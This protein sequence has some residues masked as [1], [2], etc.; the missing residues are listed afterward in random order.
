MFCLC[1]LLNIEEE[2]V[3][4]QV[5]V[6]PVQAFLPSVSKRNIQKNSI[7]FVFLQ[8]R[9]KLSECFQSYLLGLLIYTSLKKMCHWPRDWKQMKLHQRQL[10]P[11]VEV[12]VTV[13]IHKTQRR[14]LLDVDIPLFFTF[15]NHL[16]C[17]LVLNQAITVITKVPLNL[18]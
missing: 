2:N 6:F 11:R 18:T 3:F 14:I 15:N 12:R 10:F 7:F 4:L 16:N 1:L 5:D 9:V 13:T 17:T 8:I